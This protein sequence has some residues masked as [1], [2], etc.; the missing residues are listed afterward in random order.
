[1]LVGSD[2]PNPGSKEKFLRPAA[3]RSRMAA[4]EANDTEP[5]GENDL[6]LSVRLLE[7]QAARVLSSA[8]SDD[9][10]TAVV[11]ARALAAR[12]LE[13]TSNA[14]ASRPAGEN[15]QVALA[16]ADTLLDALARAHAEVDNLARPGPRPA[17]ARWVG[18][19]ET[20]GD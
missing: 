17:A 16:V 18:R 1:M 12:A 9:S 20:T 19:P 3:Y 4:L 11:L 7:R 15:A 5:A 2:D 8:R 13:F 10:R 6:A 14:R